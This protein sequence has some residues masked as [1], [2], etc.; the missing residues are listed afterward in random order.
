MQIYAKS[1][2]KTEMKWMKIRWK[3][4]RRRNNQKERNKEK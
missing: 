1:K 3:K 2:N 4:E